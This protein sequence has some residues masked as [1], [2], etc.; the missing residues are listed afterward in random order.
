MQLSKA[1][2]FA[3]TRNLNKDS[4]SMWFLENLRRRTQSWAKKLLNFESTEKGHE[5]PRPLRPSPTTNKNKGAGKRKKHWET[6]EFTI[7]IKLSATQISEISM[8]CIPNINPHMCSGIRIFHPFMTESANVFQPA[9]IFHALYKFELHVSSVLP[10]E[11]RGS[12]VFL[13]KGTNIR[14]SA[15]QNEKKHK[16]SLILILKVWVGCVCECVWCGG[17]RAAVWSGKCRCVRL[18]MHFAK[19]RL[20][21]R[22][23]CSIEKRK[24]NDPYSTFV[25]ESVEKNDH[26][27]DLY[28]DLHFGKW[29]LK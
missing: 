28:R 22:K 18:P 3:E 25:S 9:R 12:R 19:A 5:K 8:Q 10:G 11:K 13:L 20:S 15:K 1:P 17:V 24:K 6:N 26:T 2:S 23:F 7:W 27:Y 4:W 14:I 29:S 21:I 16:T